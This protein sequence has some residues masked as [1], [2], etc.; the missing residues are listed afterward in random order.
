MANFSQ[1]L[2]ALVAT[3]CLAACAVGQ[4][5][6]DVRDVRG[7]P[8]DAT[9]PTDG[10]RV[11]A[12]F[13][14]TRMADIPAIGCMVNGDC[15]ASARFCHPM[16]RMCVQCLA[17]LDCGMMMV[18][19]DA[20]LPPAPGNTQCSTTTNRCVQCSIPSDCP[21]GLTCTLN[22]CVCG[23]DVNGT[24]C[25]TA[26]S[27]GAAVMGSPRVLTG[28]LTMMQPED[29]FRFT[30]PMA[31]GAAPRIVVM[32]E[33]G[34]MLAIDVRGACGDPYSRCTNRMSGADGVTDYSFD[35]SMAMPPMMGSMPTRMTPWPDTL[36][37]RVYS[38]VPLT[39]CVR[40]ALV[41]SE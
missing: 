12:P 20:A 18:R 35:D 26:T 31:M 29:W 28:N 14:D 5:P 8:T 37:V 21:A 23:T 13:T 10:P 27:G 16:R 11:D 40:Y 17:N 4:G 2:L 15:P 24:A 38:R 22:A 30:F 6:A 41:V 19:T 32:G 3:S 7:N 33:M 1:R 36:I 39:G 25:P 34:S 9:F